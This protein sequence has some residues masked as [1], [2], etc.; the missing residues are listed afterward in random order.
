MLNGTE[1]LLP[2][3]GEFGIRDLAHQQIASHL[4]IP[5]QFYHRL[6]TDGYTKILDYTV[7]NLMRQ[8]P[9]TRL[10]R[11][12]DGDVRALLSNRYQRR[13][14]DQLMAMILPII[15]TIPEVHFPSAEI[16]ETR[17]YIKFV[18]PRIEGEVEKGDI[19]QAGGVIS[20]SE[21]GHGSLS[22]SSMFFRLACLNGAIV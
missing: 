8:E 6:Q 3:Y 10:V 12:M 7:N 18:A 5:M 13:D 20:N 19:L 11:T 9:A 15:S 1:L 22:A 14:N 21:V 16:T 2:K 17:L 4:G